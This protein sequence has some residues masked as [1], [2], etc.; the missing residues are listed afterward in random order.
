MKKILGF[1]VGTTLLLSACAGESTSANPKGSLV[2]ALRG[3]LETDALTQ[4]L[5]IDSDTESLVALSEGGLEEDAAAKILDS[6]IVVSAVQAEN[7]EDAVSQVVFTLAGSPDVEMRFVEGDLYLRADIA[8]ILETFEQ[9]PGQLNQIASQV[10]G[11][12]GFEWVEP[13]IAGEWVALKDITELAQ[14]MGGASTFQTFSGEQQEKLVNDLLKSVQQNATVTDEGEDDAGAHVEASLPLKETL[15]DLLESLGPA[16][17]MPGMATEEVFREV[18]DDLDLV[19]D[20]WI[21]D[22]R[23]TQMG[24]DILQFEQVMEA[25]GEEFPEGVEEFTILAKFEEFDGNVEPVA[26][27]VTIDTESLMQS[28]T[29]LMM[30]GMGA[31]T[32]AVTPGGGD[33]GAGFDCSVLKGAPP[34][35]VELYAEECPGLQK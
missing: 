27:A 11:Q 17:N 2:D 26:D 34:E 13:A 12:P 5:S 29:G 1:L 6:S 24:F 16:A 30:G 14:Q 3:L 10:Q 22:G 35:V 33:M 15:Q 31:G 7:P 23:V 28:L 19:I 21:A 20:F 4:T 32:G 25:E 8:H 18:P 9:D